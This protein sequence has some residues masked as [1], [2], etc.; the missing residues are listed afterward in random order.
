MHSAGLSRITQEGTA[1]YLGRPCGD[2]V[3][4]FSDRDLPEGYLQS[5][6]AQAFQDNNGR[7]VHPP[8]PGQG[9]D[10][11]NL[12]YRSLDIQGMNRPVLFPNPRDVRVN[13]LFQD[14]SRD[15]S[16]PDQDPSASAQRARRPSMESRLANLRNPFS[17]KSK[18]PVL[19][20]LSTY[21]TRP[22]RS[23]YSMLEEFGAESIEMD[24]MTSPVTPHGPPQQQQYGKSSF[25]P[26]D[27][28]QIASV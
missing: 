18:R 27:H 21:K 16:Q 5:F 26:T 4:N 6:D 11:A 13:G 28:L 12:A 1:E 23:R 2:S 10:S 14:S 3:A 22:S 25:L 7:L 8:R 19:Q 24:T 9:N 15:F 20:R 17:K